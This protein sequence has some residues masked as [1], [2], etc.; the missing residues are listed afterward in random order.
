MC[1]HNCGS[2]VFRRCLFGG[3]KN[4]RFNFA[5]NGVGCCNTCICG[6]ECDGA[7]V[8]SATQVFNGGLETAGLDKGAEKRSDN[9]KYKADSQHYYRPFIG[10]LAKQVLQF[11]FVHYVVLLK[12]FV[13]NASTAIA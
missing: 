5:T 12:F 6:S 4:S 10:I 2:G 9:N 1:K 7:A 3:E 11:G 8:C 13:A